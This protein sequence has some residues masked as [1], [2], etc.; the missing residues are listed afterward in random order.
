MYIQTTKEEKKHFSAHPT[1]LPH[2]KIILWFSVASRDCF[3]ETVHFVRKNFV[4]TERFE[5]TFLNNLNYVNNVK[6]ITS[7]T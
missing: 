4:R 7:E 6:P 3:F 2:K 5:L 1:S